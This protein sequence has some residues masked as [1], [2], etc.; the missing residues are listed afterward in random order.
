MYRIQIDGSGPLELA[1]K[2]EK[3]RKMQARVDSY[4]DKEI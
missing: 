3:A 4:Q 1:G 2:I